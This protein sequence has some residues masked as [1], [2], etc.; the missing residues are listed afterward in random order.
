MWA[1]VMQRSFGVAREV[2]APGSDTWLSLVTRAGSVSHSDPMA[3]AGRASRSAMEHQH[4][5]KFHT[6]PAQGSSPPRCRACE[7]QLRWKSAVV[8]SGVTRIAPSC[9]GRDIWLATGLQYIRRVRRRQARSAVFSTVLKALV[10]PDGPA[11]GCCRHAIAL[12]LLA[13]RGWATGVA[14]RRCGWPERDS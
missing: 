8:K 10:G 14:R 2:T 1:W 6:E 4:T 13:G 5:D 7:G 11:R 9:R 3:R 12:D